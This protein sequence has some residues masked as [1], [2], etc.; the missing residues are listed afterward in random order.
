MELLF[1]K[2][3]VTRGGMKKSENLLRQKGMK[4][5]AGGVRTKVLRKKDLY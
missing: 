3:D 5:G 2:K 4:L 1:T